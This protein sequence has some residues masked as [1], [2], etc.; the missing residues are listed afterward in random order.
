[1][2]IADELL[3]KIKTLPAKE[4]GR[5]ANFCNE[6]MSAQNAEQENSDP[7]EAFFAILD[8]GQ[9]DESAVEND[10]R[11]ADLLEKHGSKA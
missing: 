5:I 7:L 1:M 4:L 10:P 3:E 8:E 11:L 2:P 6:Q 9:I